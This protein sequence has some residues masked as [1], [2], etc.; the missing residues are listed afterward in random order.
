MIFGIRLR[1]CSWIC[2]TAWKMLT[3]RPIDER[4]SSSGPPTF[5]ARRHGLEARLV[6][7]SWFIAAS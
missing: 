4:A 2:V 1:L 3:S 5:S 7:V 6:T